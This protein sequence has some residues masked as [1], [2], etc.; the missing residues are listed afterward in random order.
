M[1]IYNEQSM[2]GMVIYYIELKLKE[3][4]TNIRNDDF[5]GGSELLRTKPE[6]LI[7]KRDVDTIEVIHPR[8]NIIFL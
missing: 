5:N 7:K 1:E 6:Q 8:Y 3:W 4:K 2:H